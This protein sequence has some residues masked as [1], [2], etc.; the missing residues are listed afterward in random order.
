MKRMILSP[1]DTT[2]IFQTCLVK[3]M[4]NKGISMLKEGAR[5]GHQHNVGEMSTAVQLFLFEKVIINS[6][7]HNLAA[8]NYW[9]KSD[10]V[11]GIIMF[12]FRAPFGPAP[13]LYREQSGNRNDMTSFY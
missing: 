13:I 12:V 4:L 6:I 2:C 11:V 5:I 9:R 8:V 10:I 7:T 3:A 1:F